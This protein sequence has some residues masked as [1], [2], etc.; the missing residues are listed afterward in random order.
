M[1][2]YYDEIKENI[3]G[4]VGEHYHNYCIVLLEE[5]GEIHIDYP[6]LVIGKALLAEGLKTLIKLDQQQTIVFFGEE[7]EEDEEQDE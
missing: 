2:N 5:D 6:S 7:L 4:K 3:K 1:S